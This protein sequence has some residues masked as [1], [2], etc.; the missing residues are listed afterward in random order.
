MPDDAP[1]TLSVVMPDAAGNLR[2]I[3]YQGLTARAQPT[4]NGVP[5]DPYWLMVNDDG[6]RGQFVE[7]EAP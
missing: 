2:Q 3:V 4:F 5:G 7:V 1:F 6:L